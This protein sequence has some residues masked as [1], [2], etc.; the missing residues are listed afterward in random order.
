[1]SSLIRRWNEQRKAAKQR[2]EELQR[3]YSLVLKIQHTMEIEREIVLNDIEQQLT[4]CLDQE[5]C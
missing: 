2:R 5:Q 4:K 3:F 1:M